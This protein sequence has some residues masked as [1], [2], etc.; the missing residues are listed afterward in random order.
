MTASYAL[1]DIVETNAFRPG[2]R[3]RVALSIEGAPRTFAQLDQRARRLANALAAL[4]VRAGDR[5]AVLMGN[6][7]EWPEALF[8]ISALSAVCTP[9]NVLLSGHDAARVLADSGA[10]ALI[11]DRSAQRALESMPDLPPVLLMVDDFDAP[12]RARW[13]GYE[14]ALARASDSPI[15]RRPTPDAPAMMYYTSGTTGTPKGATHSHAGV[16][17]N[18]YHQIA[19]VGLTEDDVYLLVPSLSWSAGFHDVMLALMWI[20]GRTVMLPTGGLTIDRI[21]SAV[22]REGTTHTL[23]VPTLL[24]QLNE[25]P[26]AYERIRRSRLRRIFTGAE[27][28]PPSLVQRIN[29]ELPDCRVIQLYGM[30]EFPL[31]MTAM[32]SEDALRLPDRAGKPTSIV[33]LGVRDGDG[34]IGA[35]GAGEVVI[36]SPA[37][38]IGYHNRPEATAEALRDGWFH[39]GD[40][41]EIDD[42]GFLR[43]TGRAKDMIISGGMNVY[44]RE[45]EDLIQA[46]PGVRDVAV[47]GVPHDKWG[48]TPVA[49]I[50]A[51]GETRLRDAVNACC[52][53]LSGYKRPTAVLLREEPLPRTPTGKVLKRELR[54]W[55]QARLNAGAS[56]VRHDTDPQPGR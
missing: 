47:V 49:V 37:T 31:M 7:H 41:G 44:A 14:A 50:V 23:L 51:A 24:R 21:L 6:R 43:L 22:E 53:Q 33:T 34:V 17:W 32:S 19:D 30:S 39:T 45:I 4:G 29:S 52:A 42:D 28:V 18:S 12:A 54:P 15:A 26:D 9:I 55:A 11:A 1:S 16:L 3:E 35:R 40:M 13:H 2:R 10:A 46:I 20:G 48:E 56:P 36:R 25:T 5:V 8:A 38:M 27:P